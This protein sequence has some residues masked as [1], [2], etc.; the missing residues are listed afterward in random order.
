VEVFDVYKGKGIPSDKKSISFHLT[1]QSDEKTLDAK[2]ID[3]MVSDLLNKL[4]Q[5]INWEERK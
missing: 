1:Y 2:T 3:G 5:T 4:K